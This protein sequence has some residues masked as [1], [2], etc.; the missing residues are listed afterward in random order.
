MSPLAVVVIGLVIFPNLYAYYASMF[1]LKITGSQGNFLGLGNYLKFITDYSFLMSIFYSIK[2]SLCAT[3]IEVVAGIALAVLFNRNFTA[4]KMI[5]SMA[6]LPMMIAPVLYGLIFRL[7][8]NEYVGVIPYYLSKLGIVTNPLDPKIVNVTIVLI[9]VL[10]WTPFV[11]I[12]IYAGLTT[13]SNE[14]YEAAHVD[15]ANAVTCFYRITFPML[16][17]SIAITVF[18]R[19]IDAFKVYDTIYVLTNGGPGS[20]TTS[21]SL[22]IYKKAFIEGSL[23]AASAASILLTVLLAIPLS[24]TMKYVIRGNK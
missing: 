23:G 3:F 6:M 13:I 5:T 14:L 19:G 18:L 20:L 11:F 4:K 16:I 21:V 12:I 10:Q 7:I 9:D 22:F 8:L 24:F 17:P 1:D 2:F 15:G